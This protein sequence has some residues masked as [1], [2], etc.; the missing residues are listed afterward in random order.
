MKW[1]HARWLLAGLLALASASNAADVTITVNGKVVARPCTISTPKATVDLGDL[2]TFNMLS[3]GAA[4]GWH[5]VTLDLSNC[6]V[7]TSRVTATF[8]GTADSTGYYKNL[9]TAGNLQL[10]LQDTSGTRFNNGSAKTVAVN[11]A[12]QSTSFPL[13]VRALT[14][15]G[16][17]TQGTIQAVI[18]ITYTWL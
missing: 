9:G 1:T 11:D 17:P 5:S 16:G 12:T 14:V 15:N 13:R 6:P 2:Y 18:N 10:E 3:P 7:G 8:S 4:S